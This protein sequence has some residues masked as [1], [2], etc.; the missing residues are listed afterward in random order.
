MVDH[1]NQ[2]RRVKLAGLKERES[3]DSSAR[4]Q[5]QWEKTFSWE[6][7]DIRKQSRDA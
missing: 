4:P 3:G 5:T 7:K 2:T 6:T 1:K